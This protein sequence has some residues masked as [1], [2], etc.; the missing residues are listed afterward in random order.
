MKPDMH[1]MPE[2]EIDRRLERFRL[3][4]P[5]DDPVPPPTLAALVV[6]AAVVVAVGAALMWRL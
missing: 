2:T 4:M 6:I 5:E 1:Q 3:W